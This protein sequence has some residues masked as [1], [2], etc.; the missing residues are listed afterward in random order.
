MRNVQGEQADHALPG[1][2]HAPL[3][4]IG[5]IRKAAVGASSGQ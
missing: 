2:P 3:V 1:T 4:Q 5:V